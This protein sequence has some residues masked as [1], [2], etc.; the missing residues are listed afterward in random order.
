MLLLLD[1]WSADRRCVVRPLMCRGLLTLL[2]KCTLW[3]QL[4]GAVCCLLSLPQMKHSPNLPSARLLLC[5]EPEVSL[6]CLSNADT[7]S[8]SCVLSSLPA[9]PCSSMA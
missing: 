8:P 9:V 2:V 1:A 3:A 7:E 5:T 6:H 4:T